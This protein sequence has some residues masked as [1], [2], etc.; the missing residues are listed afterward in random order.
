LGNWQL[1]TV[2]QLRSGQP[3]NLTVT[4]DVANIG[5]PV[6][7]FNYERPNLVGDPYLS[8]PT[9]NEWFNT[10]AFAVP[11]FGSFGN[12]GKNVLYSSNVYNVDLSV[13]KQ[14]QL[15]ENAQR[16]LQFRAEAFNVLN[17]MN[18]GIPGTTA[19]QPG[20][21]VISGIASGTLPRQLQLALKLTF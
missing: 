18:Y 14:F 21:G 19:S 20:F 1:N 11:A 12:L 3:F 5:D 4:G 2:T 13:F 15:G 7:W 9:V 16:A 17:I 8:H 6:S 10:S